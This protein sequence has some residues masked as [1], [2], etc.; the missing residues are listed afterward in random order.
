MVCAS[1]REANLHVWVWCCILHCQKAQRAMD[2]SARHC[3][4]HPSSARSMALD[5]IRDA[6]FIVIEDT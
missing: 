4:Q 1:D 5:D 3:R 6:P 2:L